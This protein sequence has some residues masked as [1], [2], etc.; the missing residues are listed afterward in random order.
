MANTLFTH[1]EAVRALAAA[2]GITTG[3]MMIIAEI[4]TSITVVVMDGKSSPGAVLAI[5]AIGIALAPADAPAEMVVDLSAPAPSVEA[6]AKAGTSD[7]VL[8]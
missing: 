7:T 6:E 8:N 2:A 1:E 4:A 5:R 3:R